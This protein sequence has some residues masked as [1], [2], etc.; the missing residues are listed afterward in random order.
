MLRHWLAR[1]MT[2]GWA[3]GVHDCD[4]LSNVCMRN[5]SSKIYH[6]VWPLHI[7][8]HMS[9][10]TASFHYPGGHT[11][12]GQFQQVPPICQMSEHQMMECAQEPHWGSEVILSDPSK[13]LSPHKG[14]YFPSVSIRVCHHVAPPNQHHKLPGPCHSLPLLAAGHHRCCVPSYQSKINLQVSD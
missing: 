3:M 8:A 6:P 5:V 10:I 7:Q 1:E 13:R 4:N 11:T 14:N 2:G 9:S 12:V